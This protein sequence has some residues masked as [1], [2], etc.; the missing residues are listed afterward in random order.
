MFGRQGDEHALV[1]ALDGQSEMERRHLRG[2]LWWL[3]MGL[4]HSLTS[5]VDAKTEESIH[6]GLRHV[7]DRRTTLL[8]AHRRSTLYL[9]D[10]IV[11]VDNG[12]V[13][14]SG[15]HDDLMA[16]SEVY[17]RLLSGLELEPV[18][19]VGDRIEGLANIT[20]SVE[21]TGTGGPAPDRSPA[22][23][24]RGGGS[25]PGGAPSIGAGLGGS[26]G[27]WRLN[28]APTP[29]LMARVAALRPI[30][31]VATV[32]EMSLDTRSTITVRVGPGAA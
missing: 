8:I 17:R 27:S 25:A 13:V 6:D 10:R 21:V 28:L 30:R 16:R 12:R 11:V 23:A 4:L 20:A 19:A 32:D 1:A 18:K 2:R 5:A 31:D 14:E 9:A 24:S 29:E 26:G 3:M 22:S 7:L 15:T